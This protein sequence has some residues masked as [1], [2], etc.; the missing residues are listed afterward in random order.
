M[1][2][3]DFVSLLY[4]SQDIVWILNNTCK[5]LENNQIDSTSNSLPWITY[6]HNFYAIHTVNFFTFHTLTNKMY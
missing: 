6:N 3:Q 5:Y 2:Q 4:H 1:N